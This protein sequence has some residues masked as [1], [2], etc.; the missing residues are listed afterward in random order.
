MKFFVQKVSALIHFYFLFYIWMYVVIY[1][2]SGLDTQ[3][4]IRSLVTYMAFRPL[5]TYMPLYLFKVT[6]VIV[7]LLFS[8]FRLLQGRNYFCENF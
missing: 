2:T 8:Y 1:G 3:I 5:V 7:P 6:I 4:T